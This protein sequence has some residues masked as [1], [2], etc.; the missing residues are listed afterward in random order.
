MT[1]AKDD[2]LD[3]LRQVRGALSFKLDGLSEYDLR[4]PLTP[5]GTNLLGLVKHLA[6]VEAG[7]LGSC[8]G[9]PFPEPMPW[10]DEGAGDNA[11]MWVTPQESTAE[12]LDLF[13]RVAA[14]SEAT[15]TGLDLQDRGTV[16]W[17]PE[18]RRNPTLHR[19]LIHYLAEI[20]RHTGQADILREQVDG[21]IGH[22][23]DSSNL[24]DLD[25]QQ[26]AAYRDTVERAAREAAGRTVDSADSARPNTP[27]SA[28]AGV[29]PD[30]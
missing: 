11:D 4:R 9:R 6:S 10:L 28:A 2:L 22:R 16:P 24:P 23:A 26:W 19:V 8:F 7:Y 13:N 21:A 20:N 29:L 18:D 27:G 3:Y 15:I 30:R 14:H 17:W 12:I 1:D 25:Q 5:T